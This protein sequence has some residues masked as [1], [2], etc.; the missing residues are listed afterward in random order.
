MAAPYKAALVQQRENFRDFALIKSLQPGGTFMNRRDFAKGL[1][2]LPFIGGISS[3]AS[4]CNSTCSTNSHSL[5]IALEGPFAVVVDGTTHAV[6]AFSPRGDDDHLFA[7]DGKVYDQRKTYDFTMTITPWPL[8]S[9][10]VQNDTAPFCAEGTQFNPPKNDFISLQLPAPQRIIVYDNPDFK[11]DMQDNTTTNVPLPFAHV[12]EYDLS[13]QN[14][15]DMSVTYDGKTIVLQHSVGPTNKIFRFEVGLA[16]LPGQRPQDQDPDPDGSRATRFHN[17]FILPN[18]PKL[19]GQTINNIG[20]VHSLAARSQ[21]GA[22][23]QHGATKTK[24][25]DSKSK[26]STK[27]KHPERTFPFT[28]TTFEC[29]SGG[30]LV[31]SS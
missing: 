19:A 18:F 8:P 27:Q 5:R 25:E 12:L 13:Q 24:K 14:T 17:K 21:A 29:K 2:A 4:I 1:A 26:K 15:L 6:T 30:L 7:L 22:A 9:L 3:F 31:T 23:H 28:T 11:A 16:Q 10:C 20:Q